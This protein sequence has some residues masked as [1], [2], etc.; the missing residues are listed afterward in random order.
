MEES[1]IFYIYHNGIQYRATILITFNIF[2]DQYCIYTI[3]DESSK[4]HNVYCAKVIGSKLIKIEN[5]EEKRMTNK[6]VTQLIE[7]L[8]NVNY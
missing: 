3:P 7:S 1:N 6:V 2:D 8:K 5:E 4:N